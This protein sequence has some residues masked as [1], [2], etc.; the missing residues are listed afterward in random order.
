M[1]ILYRKFLRTLTPSVHA[2]TL[3]FF[4]GYPVFSWF[5]GSREGAPDV[6]IYI[7]NL[8]DDGQQ[9]VIGNKDAI[10]RWNPVLFC[11]GENIFLFEKIGTFCDRWST[12]MH[13]ITGWSNDISD[14][15]ING[16]AFVF[17]SGLNGSVKTK[18]IFLKD[19]MFCGSSVESILDWSSFIEIYKVPTSKKMFEF[20]DRSNPICIKNKET[21][22]DLQTG[23][24]KKT[25]GIIQPSMWIDNNV[26]YS[27]F[28]SSG[29]LH[30][31]YYSCSKEYPFTKWEDPVPTDFD[32]PN[33]SVDVV[34][35]NDFIY[36]AHN[37]SKQCRYPLCISKIDKKMEVVDS[38]V[39][40][41]NPSV[42]KGTMEFSYPYL[43]EHNS[44]L[45]LV[46]TCQRRKIE[47]CVISMD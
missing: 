9:I 18:P 13:N 23:Q 39:I 2:A 33:S 28:R 11:Y 6:A 8:N 32:N 4:K 15:E 36:L 5:G 35:F 20:V 27:F 47:H 29:S 41:D 21:Y 40:N 25:M 22:S 24:T 10:P 14:K 38:V 12:R 46:Y 1:K 17:P 44:L 16:S 30:K 34:F 42:E 19:L 3:A 45:H 43:V 31:I 26:M 37:P 7:D